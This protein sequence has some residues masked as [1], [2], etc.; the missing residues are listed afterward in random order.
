MQLATSGGD[1][2][3]MSVCSRGAIARVTIADVEGHGE[4][5]SVVAERLRDPLRAHAD[6]WDQSALIRRLN[7]GF[8]KGT[9]KGQYATAFLLSHYTTTGELLFTNAGHV[10]PLWYRAAARQWSLES[11][12][13]LTSEASNLGWIV[14][15]KSRPDCQPVRPQRRERPWWRG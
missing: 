5:V 11:T 1:L 14:C 3:Y 4:G 6:D 15:W 2:Y 9:I 10:P 12:N 7:D 13:R 8:L